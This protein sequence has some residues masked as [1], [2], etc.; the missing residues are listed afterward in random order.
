MGREI[1]IVIGGPACSKRED[2]HLARE[3]GGGEKAPSG[4]KKTKMSW[5]KNIPGRRPG[6]ETTNTR[7]AS[8]GKDESISI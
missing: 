3:V 5:G 6:Q 1:L 8:L 4:R 2:F 7:D